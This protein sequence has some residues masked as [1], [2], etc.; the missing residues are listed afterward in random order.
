VRVAATI[1]PPRVAVIGLS[2]PLYAQKL[3]D[4][5][6]TYDRQLALYV[7]A[8]NGKL[9]VEQVCHCR[10]QDEVDRAVSRA[11]T[12]E[13]DALLVV[14]LCYT[15]SMMS[16]PSLM[17]SGLPIVVW[18]T[19]E[20]LSFGA[21][22]DFDTLLQHHTAQG[23][24]DVASVLRRE[25]AMFTVESGHYQDQV[26]ICRLAT[27]LNAA[28]VH[29]LAR[30]MR[31]GRIGGAFA[32]MGDF[33]ID[34]ETIKQQ[35]GAVVVELANDELVAAARDVTPDSLNTAMQHDRQVYETDAD[36]DDALHE[37]SVRMELGLRQVVDQH[38]LD[39][40]SV[41]FL[42]MLDD[43]QT[44]C[45]PFLGINK[46]MGEG[47]G[48]AGEGDVLTA[49]HM[50]QMRQ[51]CGLAT[52][53]EIYT[54][55][56]LNN[57]LMMSH[58]QE[59]NPAMARSDRKIRLVR[60][61]FWSPGANDYVGMHFTLEPGPVTLV[62]IVRHLDG[63]FGYVFSEQTIDDIVPLAKFD[64][65]HWIVRLDQPAG[66]WLTRYSLE[67]GMHHLVGV[68]GHCADRLRALAHW[69]GMTCVQI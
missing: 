67:G 35:W 34:P 61:A 41:N 53:T 36:V 6:P 42:S 40:L 48:Y 65:P 15:A 62:S 32:D 59:C 22:Y 46:L 47:L 60:K 44:L 4:L 50:A 7:E 56:Y 21:D 3:P 9:L 33:S 30:K 19:Q 49:M 2:L 27:W 18:N 14:P 17:Q 57:R 52:F 13:A 39:G 63:T 37:R 16:V 69:Q 24:Q 31:I 20:A 51:L 8:L 66:D 5:M 64:I 11:V 12:E 54:I 25:G 1:E 43:E 58:M 55:D 10:N 45:L 29:R 38:E 23:V 26:V 28:R 68:A